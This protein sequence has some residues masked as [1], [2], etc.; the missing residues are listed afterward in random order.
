M[1]DAQYNG[2]MKVLNKILEA[3]NAHAAAAAQERA[4]RGVA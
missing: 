2:L 3:L 4:D 1:T